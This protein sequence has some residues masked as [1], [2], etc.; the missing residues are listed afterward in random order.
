M[1][2]SP[3]VTLPGNGYEVTGSGSAGVGVEVRAHETVTMSNPTVKGFESV[4]MCARGTTGF[5]A[6]NV[7]VSAT[8]YA[9]TE[10]RIMTVLT[11]YR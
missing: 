9:S 5:E 1:I 3:N 10:A 11:V 4:G 6:R 2:D 8:L 7:S